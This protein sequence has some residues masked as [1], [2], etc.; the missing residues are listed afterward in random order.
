MPARSL[1]D[2]LFDRTIAVPFPPES[3]ASGIHET[4]YHPCVWYRRE[5]GADELRDAG[6]DE[7]R[8]RILLHF[9]AVDQSAT[10]WVNGQVVATHE[11]GQSPLDRKSTRLNSS[12]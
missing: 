7:S 5:F 1:R 12:H 4:G 2:V 9:G 6:L 8:R 10:V 11:G 3:P